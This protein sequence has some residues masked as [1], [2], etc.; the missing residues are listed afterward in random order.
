[1]GQAAWL[2]QSSAAWNHPGQGILTRWQR[3]SQYR[4]RTISTSKL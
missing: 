2:W 1:M 4:H 3:A